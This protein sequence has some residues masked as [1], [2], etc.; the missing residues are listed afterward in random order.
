MAV[1]LTNIDLYKGKVDGIGE[2]EHFNF[3]VDLIGLDCL[4]VV[5]YII[6]Y[7]ITSMD[8]EMLCL[9]YTTS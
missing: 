8:L 5:V 6:E 1:L 2:I 7:V 3:G 4:F 9:K